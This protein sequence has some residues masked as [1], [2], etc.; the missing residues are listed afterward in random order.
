MAI[1]GQNDQV[2]DH[3]NSP[4]FVHVLPL[5]HFSFQFHCYKNILQIRYSDSFLKC[6]I[7]NTDQ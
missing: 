1:L 2:R 4:D 3:H 5:L 6:Q 7:I